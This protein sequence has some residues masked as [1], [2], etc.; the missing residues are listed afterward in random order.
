MQSTIQQIEAAGLR[1]GLRIIIGGGQM[2][3]TVR[4][5]TGADAFGMDAMDAVDF[6]KESVGVK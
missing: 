5:H 1:S 6:A 4:Q 2:D 3:E